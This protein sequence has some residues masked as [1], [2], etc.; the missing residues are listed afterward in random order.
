VKP[1]TQLT[2]KDAPFELVEYQQ[3]AFQEMIER[4]MTAPILRHFDH[5][6][7]HIVETNASDCASGGILSQRDDEGVLHP[8][9]YFPKTH[10]LSECNY[11]I[12]IKELMVISKALVEWRPECEAV[13]HPL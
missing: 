8:V 1:I 5:E 12:N 9:V 6:R 3:Q 10:S 2:K 11:N 13:V 7:E 4:F